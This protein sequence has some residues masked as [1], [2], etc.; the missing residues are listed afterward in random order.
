[1][2]RNSPVASDGFNRAFFESGRAGGLLGRIAGLVEDI[3]VTAGIVAPEILRGGLTAEVAI[4]ASHIDVEKPGNVF[5]HLLGSVGHGACSSRAG[6]RAK[7]L[8]NQKEGSA[9]QVLSESLFSR[10]LA[11]SDST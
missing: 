1:M 10:L 6:L 2:R 7:G 8:R 9:P 3:A 4:D 11:S 5:G